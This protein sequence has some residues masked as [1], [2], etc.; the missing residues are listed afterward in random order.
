[1]YDKFNMI[2]LYVCDNMFCKTMLPCYVCCMSLL[3]S[4][5]I[6]DYILKKKFYN[7][8][9]VL[10]YNFFVYIFLKTLKAQNGFVC[11]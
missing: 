9:L 3:K 7:T 4:N 8:I 6:Q 5:L 10:N 1:M 2:I 11:R